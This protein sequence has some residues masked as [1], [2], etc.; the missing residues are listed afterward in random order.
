[1]LRIILIA[2][3]VSSGV[4]L[5]AS[6]GQGSA[7]GML[8][9]VDQAYASALRQAVG[10]PA[11][12]DLAGQATARLQE[13][14]LVVPKDPAARL[15][16]V[17]DRPVPPDFAGL[18]LGAEGLEAAGTIRFVPAGFV[19]ADDALSWSPADMLSSLNDTIER[20]NAARIRQNLEPREARR[21]IA[22]PRYDP[23]THQLVWAALIVPK[24]APREAE[25]EITYHA[26]GFGR[27]GY[28][29][30]S[31]VTSVEKAEVIAR[32]ADLFLSG[33]SFAPGKAFGDAQPSDPRSPSGL[34]GAMG[35]DSLHEAVA[36]S[37]F[38]GSDSMVP[39]VGSGV[40]MVGALGM[41]IYINRHMRRLRRRV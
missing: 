13:A 8:E 27:Y 22:A 31:V 34:A 1:L 14:M 24:S 35:I 38:W 40:A 16:A 28:I 36:E 37:N 10:A 17:L 9:T 18:L 30:L 20:T 32:M 15:L 11:R 4:A 2:F 23:E 3:L 5:A 29:E 39:L 41:V 7:P 25:G 33:L 26:I 21:W 19:G 6:P 12:V